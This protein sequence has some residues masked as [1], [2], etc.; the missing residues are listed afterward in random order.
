MSFAS[1]GKRHKTDKI[2]IKHKLKN[3]KYRYGVLLYAF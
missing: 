1:K 3:G 2:F